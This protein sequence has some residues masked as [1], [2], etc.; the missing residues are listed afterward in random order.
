MKK[1][2]FYSLVLILF[3]GCN[4]KK[5]NL[6]EESIANCESEIGKLSYLNNN[7]KNC[8]CLFD[9]LIK[10]GFSEKEIKWY[11]KLNVFGASKVKEVNL[12]QKKVKKYLNKTSI[13][14]SCSIKWSCSNL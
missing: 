9:E 7:S 2:Y 13:L 3:F 14:S 8:E 12:I 1:Y 10:A 11:M 4:V 5:Q 6:R